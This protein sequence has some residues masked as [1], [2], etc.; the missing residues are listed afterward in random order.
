MARSSVPGGVRSA[1]GTPSRVGLCLGLLVVALLAV[2]S[3]AAQGS[4]ASAN[5]EVTVW[6]RISNPA[7]LY[8]STRPEG[9]SWRTLN[10]A[11]DMSRRSASGRFHQSNA[12]TVS[13][14]LGDLT[15][16]VEVTVWRRVANPERLYVSTRPEG[17]SWRTLN[18]ALDMS[19]RSAS[20]RF[21]QSNAV[22]VEV[23]FPDTAPVGP[24]GVIRF[25]PE[26]TESQRERFTND[27]RYAEQL[28]ADRFDVEQ[29]RYT[30]YA[31]HDW[32]DA[33]DLLTEHGLSPSF[34]REQA[35][36][37][38]P[39]LAN[40]FIY[41][42]ILINPACY[43]DA[44]GAGYSVANA[45]VQ[46]A[47]LTTPLD[48]DLWHGFMTYVA[49]A[50]LGKEQEANVI[51]AT[52]AEARAFSVSLEEAHNAE[53]P[54]D[55]RPLQFLTIIYLAETFGDRDLYKYF[56]S[57][58]SGN[59]TEAALQ[60]A[61]GLSLEE[62]H[63]NFEFYRGIVAEPIA[64]ESERILILGEGALEKAAEIRD[65]VSTVEQWF[66]ERFA[67]P[68]GNAVWRVDSRDSGCGN[69]AS[70]AIWIG[71]PCLVS[72]T[73][74]AHEYF[75]LLQRD[76]STP[77][78]EGYGSARSYPPFMLE[79]SAAYI[80]ARYRAD[81]SGR[82]W[83]DIRADIVTAVR[84]LEIALDDPTF[85]IHPSLP[86]YTLGALAVEWLEA[87]SGKS[88]ADYYY[89]LSQQELRAE[90]GDRRFDLAGERAFRAFWGLTSEEFY[91]QFACWRDRGFPIA[92]VGK[93]CVTS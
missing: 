19:R 2:E 70:T 55:T 11:L 40:P 81:A 18:T 15:A 12:V 74:Y 89:A 1:M 84:D 43:R 38:C 35:S 76:W 48:R 93:E 63:K 69:A 83:S 46:T 52:V 79:G 32:R 16:N 37:G 82:A 61:F 42:L 51:S 8:V 92:E 67:Y 22:L 25:S 23:P 85:R 20:G 90:D 14:P 7:Q 58:S 45:A 10:T 36:G 27:V 13:V 34:S 17:G 49:V 62:F 73:A 57:L 66:E 31:A 54:L 21:H 91:R 26:L 9:G 56:E 4:A 39:L 53:I 5:V 33:Y 80:H 71:E 50:T 44:T 78:G 41:N 86:E 24:P 64:S 59:S 3:V 68:A 87:R 60:D 6:R 47:R 65:I 77:E 28:L 29:D 88:V 30:L 72:A 75:H